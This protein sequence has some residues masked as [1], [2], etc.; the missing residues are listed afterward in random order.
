M[1]QDDDILHSYTVAKITEDM[2]FTDSSRV[3]DV[4]VNGNNIK[5]CLVGCTYHCG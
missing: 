2:D 5:I 4:V 3:K 1:K